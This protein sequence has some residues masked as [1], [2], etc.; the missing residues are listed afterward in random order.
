MT[1]VVLLLKR[2]TPEIVDMLCMICTLCMLGMQV[3]FSRH[4]GEVRQGH[5]FD[6]VKFDWP[7][8]SEEVK[9]LLLNAG[10]KEKDYKKLALGLL[11]K[12]PHVSSDISM[13]SHV[14]SDINTDVSQGAS[15]E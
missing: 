10:Q 5:W 3:L 1:A 2:Q 9:Y 4:V 12:A 13:I 6:P 8:Q 11:S 14:T 7:S 15:E